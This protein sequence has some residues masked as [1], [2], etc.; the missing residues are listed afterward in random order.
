MSLLAPISNSGPSSERPS[1]RFKGERVGERSLGPC[2]R[3]ASKPTKG[4]VMLPHSAEAL[5]KSVHPYDLSETF[6]SAR[7]GVLCRLQG[8][9]RSPDSESGRERPRR[10]R[11]PVTRPVRK[12]GRSRPDLTLKFRRDAGRLR[13]RIVPQSRAPLTHTVARLGRAACR[14]IRNIGRPAAWH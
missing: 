12:R 3:P 5:T 13:P 7:G 2:V 4:A 9:R 10:L 1:S 14:V 6:H 8:R 11:E